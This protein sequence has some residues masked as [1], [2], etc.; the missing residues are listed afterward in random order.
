MS[1]NP[2]GAD[3]PKRAR[4]LAIFL[5]ALPA[6]HAQITAK[7]GM[8]RKTI[9]RI[10]KA[11]R[12]LIRVGGWTPHPVHGPSIAIWMVGAGPD[13]PDTLPRLTR[14][15]ISARYEK[16][17]RANPDKLLRRRAMQRMVHWTKKARTT[18]QHPFSALFAGV[19]VGSLNAEG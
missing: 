3:N 8:C 13:V 6:T 5:A 15:E 14:K 1:R 16:K 4:S 19:R 11:H 7:T 18:P 2:K 12:A 9:L 10:T 17:V